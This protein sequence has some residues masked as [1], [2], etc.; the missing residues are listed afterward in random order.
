[1]RGKK[2]QLV[3][4]PVVA[5]DEPQGGA[6]RRPGIHVS[7]IVASK[8]LEPQ[9]Q[10]ESDLLK[11]EMT[12]DEARAWAVVILAA[13]ESSEQDAFLLSFLLEKVGAT[14]EQAAQILIEFREIRTARDSATDV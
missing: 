2:K 12:P 8:T 4:L 13:A 1:M 14:M 3:T 11:W 5:Q 6:D 9:V 7:G 10:F